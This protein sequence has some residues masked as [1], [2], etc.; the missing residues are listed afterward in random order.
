[1]PSKLRMCFVP[2]GLVLSTGLIVWALYPQGSGRCPQ[3]ETEI[4]EGIV[5]G[6]D[7]LEAMSEGSGPIHWVRID[8]A[9]PGIELYVTP[10]DHSAVAAG[11]QYR[12]RRIDEVMDRERLAVGINGTLFTSKSRWLRMSGDFAN[13]VETTVA[14]HVVSHVWEHT[15]L[16][17]FDDR[18]NPHLKPSKPPAAKDLFAAKWG[19]GG[20]AVGLHDGRVWPGSSVVPDSRTG[21]AIDPQRS[22]LFLAVGEYVSPRLLL[23]KLARLGAKEGMLLDGGDSSSIALGEGAHGMRPGILHGGRRPV[24]THF[25]VRSKRLDGS[26]R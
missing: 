15:Y 17:W 5:Y 1:M 12:L 26:V 8:L 9:T 11:W 16:L 19:I 24:A 22:I 3:P 4:F 14:D 21:I 23:E 10:L 20:Q 18:L 2:L 6:C 7:R 25:G 13:G